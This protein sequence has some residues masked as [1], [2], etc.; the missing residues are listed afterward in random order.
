MK[1]P[2]PVIEN[3]IKELGKI[4][5]PLR[6]VELWTHWEFCVY[7]RF[8]GIRKGHKHLY[9]LIDVLPKQATHEMKALQVYKFTFNNDFVINREL[10]FSVT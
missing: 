6:K 2:L 1:S 10:N 5:S 7:H 9:Q 8:F 3:F 4:C